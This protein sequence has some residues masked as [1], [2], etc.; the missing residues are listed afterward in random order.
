MSA[1]PDVDLDAMQLGN[2][3][4]QVTPGMQL[5]LD[6]AG[7]LEHFW[8][9]LIP[10]TIGACTGIAYFIGRLKSPVHRGL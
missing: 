10:L 7:F 4:M 8:Y 1:G 9:V 2:V 6:W 5:R 3:G